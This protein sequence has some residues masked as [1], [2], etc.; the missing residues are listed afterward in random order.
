VMKP[1][2]WALA[3]GMTLTASTACAEEAQVFDFGKELS[4]AGQGRRAVSLALVKRPEYTVN[5][6]AVND[7]IPTHRHE[8]GS[9][10]L[11]IVSGRG[12]ASVEGKPVELKPGVI[13]HI[14]KGVTHSIKAEGGKLTFVD[15]VQHA[16]DPN[17]AGKK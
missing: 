6:V 17:R 2:A 15:F 5:A 14:P 11:Y 13:V 1:I 3:A 9:H 16:F 7:E 4:G 12:T 8:D 10:V